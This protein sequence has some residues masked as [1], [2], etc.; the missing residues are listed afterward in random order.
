M[1]QYCFICLPFGI[2]SAPQHFQRKMSQILEGLKGVVYMMD[3]ILVDGSTQ[4]EYDSHLISVLDKIKVS[5]ATLKEDKY[6][7]S[8]K[9]IKFLGHIIDGSGI[10]PDPEP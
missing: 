5:R 7:F 2:T 3:G 8:K 10:C 9:S 4:A 1:G 6:H